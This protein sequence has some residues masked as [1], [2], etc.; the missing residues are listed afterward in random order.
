MSFYYTGL[1]VYGVIRPLLRDNRTT[2]SSLE[3]PGFLIP[4]PQALAKFHKTKFLSR[5]IVDIFK[6][7]EILVDFNLE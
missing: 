2:G 4:L 3:I 6:T 5:G 1:L 7:D